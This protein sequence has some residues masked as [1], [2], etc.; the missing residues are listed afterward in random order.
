MRTLEQI[1]ADM[2]AL[3]EERDA[4]M[5]PV[6]DLVEVAW[7]AFAERMGWHSLK[8]EAAGPE[9]RAAMR[10]AVLAIRPEARP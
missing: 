3:Q 10:A 9:Y 4:A 6:D 8:I 7:S 1:D 5:K 2:R